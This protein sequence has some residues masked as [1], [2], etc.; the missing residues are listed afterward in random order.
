[1]SKIVGEYTIAGLTE[2]QINSR[3]YQ[4]NQSKVSLDGTRVLVVFFN[5]GEPGE[6]P[7]AGA[8]QSWDLGDEAEKAAVLAYAETPGGEYTE[9]LT[10]EE[11]EAEAKQ[12]AKSAYERAYLKPVVYSANSNYRIL[13]DWNSRSNLLMEAVAINAGTRVA[14]PFIHEQKV[15]NEWVTRY[16]VGGSPVS[17]SQVSDMYDDIKAEDTKCNEALF[18]AI[19]KIEGGDFTATFEAEY[20]ALG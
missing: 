14:G 7:W 11:Q 17:N 8:I 13:R 20:A 2:G 1:M 6:T 16:T 15:N 4:H 9:A 5:N 19:T 12:A 3:P 10:V 18:N